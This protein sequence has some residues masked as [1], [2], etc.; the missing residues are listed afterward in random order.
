[1]LSSPR[2]P[3]D[4]RASAWAIAALSLL[5]LGIAVWLAASPLSGTP[6]RAPAGHPV[7]TGRT[8]TLPPPDRVGSTT[9]ERALSARR[10]IREYADRALPLADIGQLVW[11]SQGRN[12]PSGAGRTAPSAGALYPLSVYVVAGRVTG[13]TAGVYRYDV[14]SHRLQEIA[15]GD[16]RD[17]LAQAALGQDPVRRAPAVLVIAGEYAVTATKYGDRT[18]RF[19]HLEAGHAGQSL[20]LT[21]AARGLGTVPIGAFEDDRLAG[22][23]SLPDGQVPLALWPVGLRREPDSVCC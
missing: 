5:V 12:D 21:A 17:D 20:A 10:S 22:V 19:V 9:L 8:V 23:L 14:T 15:G 7:A 1:M 16:R 3:A 18:A 6:R 11:A 4:P 13:L 2:R